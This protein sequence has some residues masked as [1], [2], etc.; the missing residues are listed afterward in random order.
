MRELVRVRPRV[1]DL[2]VCALAVLGVMALLSIV[3]Y[4]Y[5]LK[6]ETYFQSPRYLFALLPLGAAVVAV[7]ARGAGRRFGPAFGAGLVMIVIALSVFAQL[8]T[9]ERYYGA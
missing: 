5:E 9:L 3:G 4:R 2:A 1:G 6:F 8:A 7:A